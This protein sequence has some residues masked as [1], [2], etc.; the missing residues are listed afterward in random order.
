VYDDLGRYDEAIAAYRRAIDRAGTPAQGAL[1]HAYARA[2]RTREAL[3]VLAD[4]K[5]QSARKHVDPYEIAII[6]IG[7]GRTDDAFRALDRSIDARSGMVLYA[8]ADPK[9]APLRSDARF[10]ALLARLKLQ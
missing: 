4:L 1:G 9:L 8:K 2:G 7:L 6:L 3:A 5:E 10:K